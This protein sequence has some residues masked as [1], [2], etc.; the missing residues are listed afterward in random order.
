MLRLVTR[1]LLLAL[2]GAVAGAVCLALAFR[3][4]PELVFEMDRDVPGVVTGLYPVE[5]DGR[6][7]FAWTHALATVSLPGADRHAPWHCTLRMRGGRP[8][9]FAQPAVTIAADGVILAT[10]TVTNEYEDVDVTVPE[11]PAAG[12][13]LTI[14]STPAFVPGPS[15]R[16]ELGMQLDRITCRPSSASS[17]PPRRAFHAAAWSGAVIG[18]GV[19]LLGLPAWGAIGSIAVLAV[20]QAIPLTSGAA[21]YVRY[22]DRVPW[23]AL[24]IVLVCAAGAAIAT[25]WGRQPL[26][27][28]ARAALAISAGALFVELLALLHPSKLVIDALFHAHRLEW[29]LSG[30]YFFTQPLPSGVRFPYAIALYVC[31]APWTVLTHDYIALLKIVVTASRALAGLMLY[32][33]I[34]RAWGDRPAGALAVALA[35]FAPLPFVVI[36]NANLTYAFGQSMATLAFAAAATWTLAPRRLAQ[37][38]ALF[39]LASV[40]YLSHVGIFSTALAIMLGTGLLYWLFGG[41][42]LRAAARAVVLTAILAAIFSVV[43]YYGHFTESYRTLAR[44]RAAAATAPAAQSPPPPA[45]ASSPGVSSATDPAARIG[46]AVD[47]AR[48]SF[49]WPIL[50]LTAVGAVRV[51]RHG[52]RDRLALLLAAAGLAYAAFVGFSVLAPVD[53]RFQ[54]YNE[55]FIS[56]LNSLMVPLVAVLAARGATWVWQVGMLGRVVSAVLVLAAAAGGVDAWRSWLE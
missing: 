30:R 12:L 4:H 36:G 9:Q 5:R 26:H 45:A 38:A 43:S 24:W 41:P 34:V 29:V 32:P 48:E 42:H 56:R 20:A 14:A 54:R 23:L 18:A 27:V 51:W 25:R 35:H 3:S 2:V 15:D 44:T 55:E 16:R 11:Q 52:M 53:P 13:T 7:T 10:R 8:P 37:L 31:A 50:L 33:M 40:A 21:P 1:T 6:E 19:G 28:A 17:M 22:V 46:R 49:G 47:L 39:A